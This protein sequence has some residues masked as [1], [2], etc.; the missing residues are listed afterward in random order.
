MLTRLRAKMIEQRIGATDPN[1]YLDTLG[2]SR[3]VMSQNKFAEVVGINTARMSQYATGTTRI[4]AHHLLKL[5]Q[6]LHC[7]PSELIGY[8]EMQAV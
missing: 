1:R 3:A 6:A 5:S 7:H 4:P 2:R 8:V